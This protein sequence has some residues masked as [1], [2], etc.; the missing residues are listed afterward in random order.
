L[1]AI[2]RVGIRNSDHP[3][4][5]THFVNFSH[6]GT[7]EPDQNCPTDNSARL[8]RPRRGPEVFEVQNVCGNF[9][10]GGVAAMASRRSALRHPCT[11]SDACPIPISDYWRAHDPTTVAGAFV[12]V[13]GADCPK[14]PARAV[15]LEMAVVGGD[16]AP[17]EGLCGHS[18]TVNPTRPH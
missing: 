13:R 14:F 12:A 4:P 1:V 5:V 7:H 2:D 10:T 9:V 3:G 6:L 16:G 8:M 15:V 17:Q 11:R 18:S